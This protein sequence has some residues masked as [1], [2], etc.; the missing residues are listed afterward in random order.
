MSTTLLLARG[1]AKGANTSTP[2][3]PEETRSTV[4]HV[5]NSEP[6]AVE[7]TP[8]GYNDARADADTEGGLTTAQ[9]ASYVLPSAPPAPAHKDERGNA[10]Q[11]RVN[12]TIA[13]GGHAPARE[14]AGEWGHGTLQIVEGIEPTIRDGLEYGRDYFA[15]SDSPVT[16]STAYMEATTVADPATQ[17]TGTDASRDAAAQRRDAYAAFLKGAMG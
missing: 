11:S 16:T 8:P 17:A 6:A 7:P 15:V 1:S 10:I 9:L 3:E 13:T 4:T 5:D 12:D 2:H 14:A